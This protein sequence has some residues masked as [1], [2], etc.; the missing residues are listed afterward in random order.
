M[1]PCP[2][3]GCQLLRMV[4]MATHMTVACRRART[5]STCKRM[6]KWRERL[7]EISGET[8]T[9]FFLC[10]AVSVWKERKSYLLTMAWRAT[11][12]LL[13][14]SRAL[15]PAL[16]CLPPGSTHG[17]LEGQPCC[18]ADGTAFPRD[19]VPFPW[20]A[21]SGQPAVPSYDASDRSRGEARGS[22]KCG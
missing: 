18:C 16:C 10:P 1:P 19:K 22:R 14:F 13:D 4:R 12:W 21:M 7:R 17:R 11:D 5:W 20:R 6:P 9:P 8:V 15:L 2:C 3:L